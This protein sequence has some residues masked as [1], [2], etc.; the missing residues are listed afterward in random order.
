[1]RMSSRHLD[2]PDDSS[3]YNKRNSSPTVCAGL[4]L[5]SIVLTYS[6]F[7]P[8]FPTNDDPV[9]TMLLRGVG[10]SSSPDEWTVFLNLLLSWPLKMLYLFIPSIP[11]YPTFLIAVLALSHF[12]TLSILWSH[13]SFFLLRLFW[14]VIAHGAFFWFYVVPDWTSVAVLS[15]GTG[16][17]TLL[18]YGRPRPVCSHAILGTTLVL[19]S[20]L[21]RGDVAFFTAISLGFLILIRARLS[22]PVDRNTFARRLIIAFTA[23]FMIFGANSLLIHSNEG[24]RNSHRYVRGLAPLY[25]YKKIPYNDST[26]PLFTHIGW[27]DM[28]CRLFKHWFG[29]YGKFGADAI[30]Y[31]NENYHFIA[32]KN[33][34][35]FFE[36]LRAHPHPSYALLLLVVLAAI[37]LAPLLRTLPHLAWIA[38]LMAA[39][40]WNLKLP[41]RLS[42]PF[43]SLSILI[44][45]Q[46]GAFHFA[47]I[48]PRVR[49]SL[50][51]FTFI[52][53][54]IL[55]THSIYGQTLRTNQYQINRE[56]HLVSS[57]KALSPQRNHLYI[58]WFAGLV[59]D[60]IGCFN[61]MEFLENFILYG[62]G[63]L[64]ANPTN[65]ERAKAFGIHDPL[66]DIID[67]SDVF[68]LLSIDHSK[69]I[70]FLKDYYRKN[71]G[72]NVDFRQIYNGGTWQTYSVVSVNP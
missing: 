9:K 61:N 8:F 10:F 45:A 40:F 64:Q 15:S 38:A 31:L 11:W 22:K 49:H 13:S 27:D 43:I 57:V 36:G 48:Q 65:L 56:A 30:V 14:V 59:P 44:A 54:S 2:K 21:I 58:H 66:K 69:L 70:S 60:Y 39:I 55:I 34:D 12:V 50:S 28:D 24:W 6:H 3:H 25:E 41:P 20:V 16:I 47:T 32:R 5:A 4:V 71:L 33:W 17:L 19:L 7:S 37:P 68:L 67:R 62:T 35:W 1:M 42:A 52:L 51:L 26:K 63:W 72:R 23:A 53:L 29:G 18:A 46:E